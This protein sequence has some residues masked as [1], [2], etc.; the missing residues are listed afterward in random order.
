MYLDN[1]ATTAIRPIVDDIYQE[2]AHQLYYN[3]SALYGQALEVAKMIA[4]ARKTIA[5]LLGVDD[6]SLVFTSCGS[7]SDTQALLCTRKKPGSR[8]IISAVEHPAVFNTA[9]ELKQR[10]YDVVTAPVDESGTVVIDEFVKLL[11]P[12]TA[13]VSIMHV[14]NVTGAIND[15]AGLVKCVKQYDSSILFHSDGV[16]AFGHIP[17]NLRAL[18]IDLYSLSGHKVGAPK[19][20]GALYVKP[21]VHL[22]P[23]V[24]GGG[25]ENGLRSGTENV[26]GILAYAV[27]AK[28]CVKAMPHL[29]SKGHALKEAIVAFAKGV[30]GCKIVSPEDGAPHIVALSFAKARGET[31]MHT[32][33]GYGILTGIGS[34]CSS[35]KG[36]ARIPKELGLKDGYEMGMV[37]LSINAFDDYDWDKLIKALQDSYEVLSKYVRS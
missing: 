16:Q 34:A 4:G 25:Q 28:A 5:G 20:V 31:V 36:T 9:M 29:V 15:I 8:V 14:N 3:P 26:L 13:L 11:T 19:G 32:L 1:A 6:K 23:L 12:N 7:E 27:C 21:G 2:V 37:R 10:G 30:D 18:G 17:V 33:E 24:Y 35:K 22:S